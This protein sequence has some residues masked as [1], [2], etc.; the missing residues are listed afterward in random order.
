MV[1]TK[2]YI[3]D[4]KRIYS[5]DFLL[6]YTTYLMYSKSPMQLY[7]CKHLQIRGCILLICAAYYSI[8]H[9][10]LSVFLAALVLH[11]IHILLILT[12]LVL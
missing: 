8:E 4:D 10:L 7:V 12:V 5:F 11:S 2:N 3:P 1:H 6:I 9:M